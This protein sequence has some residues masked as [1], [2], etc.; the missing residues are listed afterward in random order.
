[1]N[2]AIIAAGNG[3]RLSSE[4]F[5]SP[6]PM[7]ELSPGLT[8]LERL[9]QIFRLCG[10][11]RIRIIINTHTP[12]LKAYIDTLAATYPIETVCRTTS[13]SLESLMELHLDPSEPW[14]VTTA[15]TVFPAHLFSAM[16][17]RFAA[18]P[19]ADALMGLTPYIDDEK[20]LYATVDTAADI[21]TGYYDQTPADTSTIYA[22]GGIYCLRPMALAALARCRE[23]GFTRMR[24]YQKLLVE[25]GLCVRPFIYPRIID[26]D[27]ISDIDKARALISQPP[28]TN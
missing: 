15:D 22:S 28:T 12:R 6:K 5:T 25:S 4:G 1:M 7:V 3:S 26:V 9:L 21:V 16:V 19:D 17:D 23:L 10:T 27:H 2:F 8:M 11:E 14:I 20:P 24:Q 18:D 13:G